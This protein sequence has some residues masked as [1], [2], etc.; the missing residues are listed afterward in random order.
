MLRAFFDAPRFVMSVVA[1]PVLVTVLLVLTLASCGGDEPAENATDPARQDD[2]GDPTV[3]PEVVELSAPGTTLNPDAVDGPDEGGGGDF[4]LPNDFL[5]EL[6]TSAAGPG[7]PEGSS[8][9]GT[10][11]SG[12]GSGVPAGAGYIGLLGTLGIDQHITPPRADPPAAKPGTFPLTGLPGDALGRAAIVVKVDNSA[13]AWPQTG[14]D[15]ADLII[16]E[17]VE[18]GITRLAAV[19]HSAGS[20][21]GPVRSGRTTDISYLSAL[22]RPVLAYSGA[23]TVTEALLLNQEVVQNMGAARSGG[24]WRSSSRSAPS[25]LYTSTTNLWAGAANATPPAQFVYR[26]D[27][28]ASRGREA[29]GA[30]VVFPSHRVDWAWTGSAWARSQAGNPHVSTNGAQLT[31]ANVIIVEVDEIPSGM[32]DSVGGVVPEFVFA[33]TGFA[34]VLSDGKAVSG[35][36]TRPTLR[37]A[38]T[39]TRNDGTVIEITPGVTWIEIVTAGSYTL[40]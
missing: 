19:F 20:E 8:T 22:G 38:A 28:E 2:D 14:L 30:A 12:N 26:D 11:T 10:A 34:T 7:V 29:S 33:G 36:W 13:K 21:V 17:E 27:G 23:N 15:R 32:K 39:L 3:N 9:P 24:Y 4:T 31:A 25:N 1:R 6:P 40:R 18:G 16:E 37:D 5:V 35:I